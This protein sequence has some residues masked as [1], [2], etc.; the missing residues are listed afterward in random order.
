MTKISDTYNPLTTEE[1][2]R[3]ETAA[4]ETVWSETGKPPYIIKDG[5]NMKGYALLE[6][7]S[8]KMNPS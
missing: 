3:F 5:L 8:L 6:K 7:K 4:I 1:A 2:N